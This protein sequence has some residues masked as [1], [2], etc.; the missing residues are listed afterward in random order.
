MP[1]NRLIFPIFAALLA[2]SA[3]QGQ[4][5]TP[6]ALPYNANLQ[7]TVISTV[8]GG[9]FV[10]ND[11]FATPFTIPSAGTENNYYVDTSFNGQSV[12]IAVS[13]PNA[14]DVY[15]LMNAT[16]PQPGATLGT[17]Q[18][19]GDGGAS[20]T[21]PLVA[22]ANI[23]DYYQGLFANTLNNGVDG[24]EAVNAFACTDPVDCLGSGATGN[25][26]TGEAGGYLLDE[27]HFT[28]DPAFASQNLTQ[29][30][31]TDATS[32][33]TFLVAG[34]TVG[35][36]AT[37]TNTSPLVSA[38]LPC[39]RSARVGTVVTAAATVINSGSSGVTGCSIAPLTA[40]PMAFLYQA[41]DP[42]TGQPVGAENTPVPIAA[43]AAQNFLIGFTPSAAFPPTTVELSYSCTGTDAATATIGINTILLSASSTPVPDIVALAATD[44]G[45][46][47]LDIP[48]TDGA[49]AFAVATVNLGADSAITVSAE[50]GAASLPVTIALC[51]TVP[52][53]GQ[54]VAAP[55]TSVATTIAAGDTPT[56]AFFVQASG[57][58]P[59]LPAVNRVF[60]QFQDG[61]GTVRGATSVALRTQ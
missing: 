45:D 43:G 15:T 14:T 34:V 61:N 48:G 52:S 37:P 24:V 10:A 39:S 58:V 7:S 11:E 60:V 4:V 46:G 8:P 9:V 50:T 16:R 21:F 42:T 3:A 32:D 12:T 54:C 27:Q 44:S 33:S 56:F 49:A 59:F 5:L 1:G 31:L 26:Q 57:T 30:V 23:R 17:I 47:I 55:A 40:L 18:F 35:S 36:Q 28:L 41:L 6:V 13:I 2:A 25:V 22:G 38:V 19:I 53:T 20:Q 29:I 51:Q